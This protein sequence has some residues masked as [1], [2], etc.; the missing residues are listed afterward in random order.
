[1]KP[2]LALGRTPN[3][4][5]RLLRNGRSIEAALVLCLGLVSC[6]DVGADAF[7][8]S[9]SGLCPGGFT[10]QAGRCYRVAPAA[11]AAAREAGLVASV[12][13]SIDSRLEP[14]S[15]GPGQRD[16]NNATIPPVAPPPAP[17]DGPA[18]NLCA[19]VSC[20]YLNA[21]STCDPARGTC[22]PPVCVDG[23]GDCDG[24]PGCESRLDAVSTC[25]SC[26]NRCGQGQACLPP[27]RCGCA[28]QTCGSDCV[29]FGNSETHCGRCNRR[30]PAGCASGRCVCPRPSGA[31]LIDDGGLDQNTGGWPSSAAGPR[32]TWRSEDAADC[33]GSG[34][35]TV[36]NLENQPNY[37]QESGLCIRVSPGTTYDFGMWMKEVNIVSREG[38]AGHL[39]LDWFPSL[40]CSGP[41]FDQAQSF[42]PEVL[43]EWSPFLGSARAPASARS[44]MLKIVV[45]GGGNQIQVDMLFV[46]VSPA[47]FFQ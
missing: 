9:A 27:G 25:G 36:H 14:G 35:M 2:A 11:D 47:R 5:R 18:P 1:L 31:N 10:S 3:D 21:T 29:D 34:S 22:T 12:D 23:F 30:C 45:I 44:A 33:G 17:A 13:A 41:F 39:V 40:D 4:V 20:Q 38:G 8:A 46:G 7:P 24:S 16:S 32:L 43:K 26:T 6:R 37:S 19:G 28:L 42:G 15:D